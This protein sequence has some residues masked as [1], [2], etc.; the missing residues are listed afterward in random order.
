MWPFDESV[1]VM[2]QY[3]EKIIIPPFSEKE[4]AVL[5]RACKVVVIEPGDVYVFSGA[6]AH[7]AVGLGDELNLAAYEAVLNF[8]PANLALF[9]ECNTRRHHYDC[10][11]SKE[12]FEEWCEDV[13]RNLADLW[14][15]HS[16]GGGKKSQRIL[17]STKLAVEELCK[18]EDFVYEF[19]S[20]RHRKRRRRTSGGFDAVIDDLIP[21]KA[22]ER[23]SKWDVEQPAA[24][25]GNGQPP[26]PPPAS[27][28]AAEK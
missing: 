8:H 17:E 13:V 25:N 27:E 6:G 14:A 23:E 19:D 2:D 1:D 24:A 4:I 3:Y 5:R 10:R 22:R 15:A 11:S 9:R 18:D 16:E 20:Y 12:D 7:M 28:P 21:L 26:P